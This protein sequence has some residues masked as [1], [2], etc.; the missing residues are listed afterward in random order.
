MQS[1][2]V[3][4]ESKLDREDQRL[5]RLSCWNKSQLTVYT[6]RIITNVASVNSKRTFCNI[7]VQGTDAGGRPVCCKVYRTPRQWSA[8][9]FSSIIEKEHLHVDSN[10]IYR[11]FC[12][13]SV[14][15]T[16][17]RVLW[18]LISDLSTNFET[19][20]Q[21]KCAVLNLIL[22]STFTSEADISMA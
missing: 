18:F 16:I 5:K 2:R 20:I 7:V 4:S 9:K 15:P 10:L 14:K 1:I 8:R 22:A 17:V 19:K 13:I 21:L 12:V 3:G 11:V 6:L